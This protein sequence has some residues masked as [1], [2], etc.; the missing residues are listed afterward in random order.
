METSK[1]VTSEVIPRKE[2]KEK[3]MSLFTSTKRKCSVWSQKI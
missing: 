3:R 2:A 1:K